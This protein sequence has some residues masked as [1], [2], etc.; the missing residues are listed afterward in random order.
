MN[1]FNQHKSTIRKMIIAGSELSEIATAI[2]MTEKK[3]VELIN[4][5]KKNRQFINDSEKLKPENIIIKIAEK[6]TDDWR[7]GSW[8][9]SRNN[10][11]KFSDTGVRL[12]AEKPDADNENEF[13][14]TTIRLRDSIIEKHYRHFESGYDWTLSEGGSR[15]FEKNTLIKTDKGD[16]K[17]SELVIGNKVLSFNH[18]T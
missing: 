3:L 15:C 14:Q 2:G 6:A 12:A 1:S 13:L 16:I 5:S 10:P 17:I 8:L 4:S 7:A 9:L 11:K 18:L